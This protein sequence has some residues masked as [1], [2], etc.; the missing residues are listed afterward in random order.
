MPLTATVYGDVKVALAGHVP[1]LPVCAINGYV[2]VTY[3]G[4]CWLDCLVSANELEHTITVM[5]NVPTKSFAYLAHD[6]VLDVDP[7][8]V[9]THVSPTTDTGKKEMDEANQAL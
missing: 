6:D 9:L 5:G 2:P 8:D 7:S 4:L 1:S 3:D